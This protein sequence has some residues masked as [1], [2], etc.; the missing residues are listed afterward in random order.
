MPPHTQTV[1]AKTPHL[2]CSPQVLGLLLQAADLSLQLLSSALQLVALLLSVSQVSL[3][4][5]NFQVRTCS[6]VWPESLQV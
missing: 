2:G 3:Q 6:T 4:P 1:L 5:Q